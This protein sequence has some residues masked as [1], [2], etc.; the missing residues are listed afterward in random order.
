MEYYAMLFL[1]VYVGAI[2]VLFLFIIMMLEIK[3]LNI[4]QTMNDSF[5]FRHVV[6]FIFILSSL[7]LISENFFDLSF[8]INSSFSGKLKDST[9]FVEGNSYID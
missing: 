8:F 1:I 5:F 7:L 2:V 4:A 6:I 9:V 3:M